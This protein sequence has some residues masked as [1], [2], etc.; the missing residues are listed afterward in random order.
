MGIWTPALKNKLIAHNGSV[1]NIPEIP[2]DL[3]RLYRTVWEISQKT[4]ID[5]AADRGAFIDQSQ[6]MNIH[7][8]N[9]TNAVLT[10]MHFHGWRKGLKTGMYYLRTKPATDAIKFTLS[11]EEE[12][13][14]QLEYEMKQGRGGD[15]KETKQVVK[16]SKLSELKEA[17]FKRLQSDISVTSSSSSSD[18]KETETEDERAERIRASRAK[19]KA[20]R[21]KALEN[22]EGCGDSCGS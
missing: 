6:S 13:R 21:E 4:I 19:W 9:V 5:M 1:Q 20:I 18:E 22:P 11:P 2:D 12:K 3:K 14:A 15:V 7:L 17:D 10:S 8:K 16:A